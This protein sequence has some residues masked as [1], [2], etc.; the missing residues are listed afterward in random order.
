MT[1]HLNQNGKKDPYKIFVRITIVI[2]AIALISLAIF[3]ICNAW[4]DAEYN[5]TV[6]S[7]Y[8]QNIIDEQ[9][10]NMQMSALRES[11]SQTESVIDETVTDLETWESTLDGANW[12]IEDEGAA[13]LEN[14]YTV[15]I[16]NTSLC[17]GG[18]MLVNA[19]HFVPDYFSEDNLI[20]VGNASGWD[21]PVTDSSIRL[22]PDAFNALQSIYNDAVAGGLTDYI[23]REAY[24]SNERQ[25]ELFTA[26]MDALSDKYSGTILTEQAK[27]TVNY[28]GTSE[29]QTGLSFRMRLYNSKDPAVAKQKFQQTEQGKWFTDNCWK[30]GII[31]RFPSDDY[32]NSSWEDK[33]YKTGVSMHLDLYRYVGEPHALVMKVMGYCLEEYVEF[34]TDHPHISIYENDVLR[35]EI[36]RINVNEQAAYDLPITNMSSSYWASIDNMGAI[37]MAY[38]YGF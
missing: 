11:A 1:A 17:E 23:V 33:S 26:R 36:V 14:T 13:G 4:V 32:P 20:S 12:R 31:F 37:V 9:A 7:I 35:Y 19:W 38:N 21:I 8:Q 6:D 28:P 25:T 3:F 18:L 10:F 24:R 22:F 2:A 16:N 30:Y 27:K 15:T 29:Y 34:L 5:R